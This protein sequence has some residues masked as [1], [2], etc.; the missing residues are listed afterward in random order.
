MIFKKFEYVIANV[1]KEN[2]ILT[3]IF[4]NQFYH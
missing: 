4:E 2:S 3:N 1:Q